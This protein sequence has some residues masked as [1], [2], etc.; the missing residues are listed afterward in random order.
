MQT[1]PLRRF[2]KSQRNKRVKFLGYDRMAQAHWSRGE[3]SEVRTPF[4]KLI[5]QR[6][7][8]AQRKYG[9]MAREDRV[10]L[11]VSQFRVPE[12]VSGQGDLFG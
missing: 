10:P 8:L 2:L 1:E 12:S 6:Y 4:R 5:A 7:Y 3:D 11:D 9:I